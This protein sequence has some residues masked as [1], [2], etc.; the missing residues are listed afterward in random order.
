MSYLEIGIRISV[1]MDKKV[2]CRPLK[3]YV[4]VVIFLFY[5]NL[6]F[7]IKKSHAGLALAQKFH[8]ARTSHGCKDAN[9]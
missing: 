2:G 4:D 6:F 8:T 7:Q 1:A 9:D 5:F 3:S